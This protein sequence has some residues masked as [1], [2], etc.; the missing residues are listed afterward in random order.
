MCGVVASLG[1]RG[2][3]AHRDLAPALD[4][5][6]SRGPDGRGVFV[7]EDGLVSLGHARL[8]L[9]GRRGGEQP[10]ASEDG[11]VVAVV[12]GELYDADEL[13]PGLEARGHRFRG[14]SDSELLVH[15]Y[16]EH[17]DAAIS[18][19][20][21]EFALI[22][23]DARAR[24]LLLARDRFGIK[25]LAYAEHEGRLLVA[26]QARALFALGLPAAWD[27]AS[28]FQAASL[29]YTLP[30]ATLFDRVR[31][32]PPGHLLVAQG[33]ALRLSKYW[34]L[35]YPAAPAEA[36]DDEA[37]EAFREAFDE[38]VRLRLRADAPVTFQLSGGVDSASVLASAA[39]S[40][41]EPA[42][43]FSVAFDGAGYD[44]ARLAAEVADHV[45]ARL[46]VVHASDEAMA[47]VFSAAVV[48]GEGL[49][50]NGHI[51]AKFLLSRAMRQEGFKATLTGEGA[52]EVL[53]GYAHLRADLEG[54]ADRVARTNQA[55][56]GLM[57]PQGEGLPLR[58][59]EAA[60]GFVPTWLQ[61][62]ATLGLRVRALLRDEVL[63]EFSSYDPAA[64]LLDAFDLPG[65]VLGRGRVEASL[66]L[67][68]RLALDGYILRTLGDGQEMAHSIEGRVP[69]LDHVLFERVRALPTGLK[70]RGQQEKFL[71]RRALGDRLPPSVSRR[72]KHPFVAPPLGAPMARLV[73]ATLRDASFRR[74]PF[75]DP[76]K[77]T[78]LLDRRALMP[79]PE[80]K[81]HDPVFFLL[82]SAASLG[83][84]LRLGDGSPL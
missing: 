68:T 71:L 74:H 44:E 24:R 33:G 67:W 29:Q 78:R 16:E 48:A 64:R 54:S 79:E 7:A 11:Q 47:S 13:R 72:E 81:A 30:D 59:I 28:F 31:A 8:A 75:F 34:D 4:A 19:L 66:Y 39:R 50:I 77:V 55:S 36:G 63:A 37:C 12:N 25:P 51:A 38:A 61:A 27:R 26:S 60:C 20:R 45:G 70:I 22:L 46:R 53:A 10:I 21:G 65:Q 2:A 62:K 18:R 69:F 82:L 43:A 42:C 84:H 80:Q 15:L 35:G 23:W 1:L 5:M 9:R 76:D 73:E 49:A 56:A 57:L 32:L 41:R 40:M 6:A 83:A 52:D 17:G 58:A 14:E 3:P